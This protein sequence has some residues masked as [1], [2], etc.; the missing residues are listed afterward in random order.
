MFTSTVTREYTKRLGKHDV[1]AQDI[2]T[3]MFDSAKS[4]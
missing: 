3:V 1:S 4:G 2:T